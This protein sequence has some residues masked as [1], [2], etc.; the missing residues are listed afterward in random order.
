MKSEKLTSKTLTYSYAIK[1]KFLECPTYDLL[2]RVPK[3]S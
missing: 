3:G 2:C 1:S